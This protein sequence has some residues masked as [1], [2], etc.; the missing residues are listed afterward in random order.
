M[1]NDKQ[2][3]TIATLTKVKTKKKM[4]F[5]QKIYFDEFGILYTYAELPKNVKCNFINTS[6]KFIVQWYGDGM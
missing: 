3:K 4:N 2:L 6:N 5:S 1:T